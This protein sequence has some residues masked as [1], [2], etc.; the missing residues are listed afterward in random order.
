MSKNHVNP[1]TSATAFFVFEK[2]WEKADLFKEVDHNVFGLLSEK[3]RMHGF[4]GKRG[5][6]LNLFS[7]S[8]SGSYI[9]VFVLGLGK[10]GE[11]EI[12]KFQDS[13]ADFLRQIKQQKIHNASFLIVDRLGI[14]SKKLGQ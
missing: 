11:F 13:V 4:S 14:D 9:D 1:V 10:R 2:E 8:R 3:A 12:N 5:E 6:V 7:R